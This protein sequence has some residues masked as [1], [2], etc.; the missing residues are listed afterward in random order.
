[1]LKE[2]R[3]VMTAFSLIQTLT[4]G[5]AAGFWGPP[6]QFFAQRFPRRKL[7]RCLDRYGGALGCITVVLTFIGT[8][9]LVRLVL[10]AI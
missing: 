6:R 4:A 8:V 1:V 7:E 10:T 9:D 5:D 2:K 3:P